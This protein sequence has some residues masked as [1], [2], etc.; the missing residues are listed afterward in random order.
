[1]T[2]SVST[3]LL[4]HLLDLVYCLLHHIALIL[5]ELSELLAEAHKSNVLPINGCDLSNRIKRA[6]SGIRIVASHVDE[7]TTNLEAIVEDQALVDEQ[8]Q[9]TD[10]GLASDILLLR[11]QLQDGFLERVHYEQP[12]L[13]G[14]HLLLKSGE[15]YVDL[16]GAAGILPS[17]LALETYDAAGVV[18]ASVVLQGD[19]VTIGPNV[20]IPGDL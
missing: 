18:E 10:A 3:P 1:M 16:S 5:T 12:S 6:D 9:N 13:S 15:E 19:L 7:L 17:S 8:L 11:E 14:A 4:C 2:A 20:R